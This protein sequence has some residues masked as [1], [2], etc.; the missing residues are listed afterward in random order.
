MLASRRTWWRIAAQIEDQMLRPTVPTKS[1]NKCPPRDKPVL[2]ATGPG[3]VW[4]WD[5]TDLYSPWRGKTYKA[6][7]VIDIYSRHMVAWRVEEREADHLA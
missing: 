4:S 2:K 3:Q 1:E 6:Y 5:I 7:S